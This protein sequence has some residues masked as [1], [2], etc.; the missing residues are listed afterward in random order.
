MASKKVTDRQ[1]SGDAVLAI[2]D[3][4]GGTLA[5]KVRPSA[6]WPGQT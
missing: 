2:F 4:Q 1:K 5:D 6:R 3:A